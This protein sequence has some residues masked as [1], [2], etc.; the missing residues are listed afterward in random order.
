ME[1]PAP[2]EDRLSD[3][4]NHRSGEDAPQNAPENVPEKARENVPPICGIGA[5][6]GGVKALQA[7]FRELP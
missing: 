1:N 3:S 4:Q 7:L 2:G 5:S 6:A